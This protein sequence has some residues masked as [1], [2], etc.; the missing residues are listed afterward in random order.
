MRPDLQQVLTD[1]HRELPEGIVLTK[2]EVSCILGQVPGCPG[3]AQ[4][5][6]QLLVIDSCLP[7]ELLVPRCLPRMYWDVSTGRW[8]MC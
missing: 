7:R 4:G 2:D 8:D 5:L 3:V 1:H 6:G